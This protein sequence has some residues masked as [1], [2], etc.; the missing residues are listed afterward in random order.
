MT[1]FPPGK[2]GPSLRDLMRNNNNGPSGSP[3]ARTP[4]PPPPPPEDPWGDEPQGNLGGGDPGIDP[5]EF[6]RLSQENEE[7]RGIVTELRGLLDEQQSSGGNQN[8]DETVR[9][10]ESMLEEKSEIIRTLHVR[11][12]ELE[13][14]VGPGGGGGGDAGEQMPAG[15]RDELAALSDELDRERCQL[16]QERRQLE[17]DRHQ[18]RE[19][20][21]SMMRQMKEMEL[22]MA[23][24]RAELARQ[25]NELQRLHAEIRHELEL[26]QRDAAVNER[27]RMLQRRHQDAAEEPAPE[28]PAEPRSGKRSAPTMRPTPPPKKDAPQQSGIFKRFL[29]GDK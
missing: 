26:A 12:Q 2:K 13:H 19:D 6:E 11:I 25:R 22:Q 21:D 9:E 23:R 16:E 15:D 4:Q 1:S 20:E 29:G 18:L 14:E 27:L 17:D 10:Y 28:P 7:L 24:E 3:P 8:N 5:A